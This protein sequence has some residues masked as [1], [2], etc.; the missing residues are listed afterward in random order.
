[1]SRAVAVLTGAD[2]VIGRGLLAMLL[3]DGYEVLAHTLEV[4]SVET[5]APAATDRVS[6]VTGDLADPAVRAR[7]IDAIRAQPVRVVVNNAARITYAAFVDTGLADWQATLE[8]N[9]TAPFVIS[10]AAAQEMIR[11]GI[12]GRIVHITSVNDRIAAPNQSAYAVSKAG[13]HMLGKAMARELAPFGIT[14]NMVGPA[15]VRSP[16]SERLWTEEAV[17]EVLPW[18][19]PLGRFGT[20][21]DVAGVVRFLLSEAA[22][23]V[24]GQVVYVDGG[25]LTSKR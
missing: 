22:S 6:L 10:Q 18:L 14:V 8:V 11:R 21:A 23:F 16:M 4:R 1:M 9:L 15:A 20:A 19:V 25:L 5:L 24:T 2:G 13:L 12:P 3:E 7:L 17:R